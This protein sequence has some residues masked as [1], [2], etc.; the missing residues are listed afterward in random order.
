VHIDFE[1]HDE[2]VETAQLEIKEKNDGDHTILITTE[3]FKLK[4]KKT[5]EYYPESAVRRVFPPCEKTQSYIAFTRLRPQLTELIGG[6]EIHL[7]SNFSVANAHENSCFTA[8]SKCTYGNTPDK[9]AAENAW[10]KTEEK[11]RANGELSKSDIEF[12]RRNFELL[13]AQRYFVPN[14][15]DFAVESVGVY[16]NISII[17]HAAQILQER[18]RG[19]IDELDTGMII[20]KRAETTMANCYDVVLQHEDYTVGKIL[21][22][23]MLE[24][25]FATDKQKLLKYCGFKKFHPH[26]PDSTIRLAYE[27]DVSPENIR[28]HIRAAATEAIEIYKKIQQIMTQL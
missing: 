1:H 27:M 5:G 24:M 26:D 9:D 14:S 22:C 15:F 13:D 21:E 23:M 28:G 18:I 7:T 8:V 12:H 3:H 4:N 19:R 6:E 16:S 20:I 17:H 2:F 11:L 25:Y 10:K